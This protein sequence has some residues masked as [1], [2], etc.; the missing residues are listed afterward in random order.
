MVLT[1][2]LYAPVNSTL[3]HGFHRAKSSDTITLIPFPVIWLARS[4]TV[5]VRSSNKLHV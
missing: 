4:G 1:N 2:T 3:L 5:L